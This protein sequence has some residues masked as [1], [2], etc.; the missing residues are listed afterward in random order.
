MDAYRKFLG[1]TANIFLFIILIASSVTGVIT[2]PVISALGSGFNESSLVST[3]SVMLAGLCLARILAGLAEKDLTWDH[4]CLLGFGAVTAFLVLPIRGTFPFVLRGYVFPLLTGLSVPKLLLC[5]LP[6]S[7][8]TD[9]SVKILTWV[10]GVILLLLSLSATYGVLFA[11]EL[12]RLFLCRFV[13]LP[14]LWFAPL[15]GF[16]AKRWGI[17]GRYT[18][19]VL[20]VLPL[21]PILGILWKR[22]FMV[23][24]FG[25]LFCV[26][27][28][29]YD[30][31]FQ[32]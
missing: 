18:S 27:A 29:L 6:K 2:Y 12:T 21:F 19:V 20:G 9:R 23:F 3:L 15:F 10:T 26:A 5:Y 16:Y 1:K 11:S 31:A 30:R 17:G 22:I 13:A 7:D 24:P 28:V 4:A 32:P 14:L 8:K 25:I